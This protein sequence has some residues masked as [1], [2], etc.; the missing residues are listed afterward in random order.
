[1]DWLN[2]ICSRGTGERATEGQIEGWINMARAN[3]P[4]PMGAVRE[5]MSED[6]GT[7]RML[8]ERIAT[9]LNVP[10]ENPAY[11]GAL[12]SHGGPTG[13]RLES[14]AGPELD[15]VYYA[16]MVFA[17]RRARVSIM[18]SELLGEPGFELLLNSYI[19]WSE[20]RDVSLQSA[21][22]EMAVSSSVALRWI[23][24]LV[25]R[26]L[27]DRTGDQIDGMPGLIRLTEKGVDLVTRTLQAQQKVY[28][29]APR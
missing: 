16:K 14:L 27:L 12:R 25:N 17:A 2:R 6:S 28:L 5:G 11:E 13:Q 15:L 24:I 22:D 29:P 8:L 4:A 3:L 26:G 20:Q 21:C 19:A 23:A 1:M 9:A 18:P 7:V 10:L